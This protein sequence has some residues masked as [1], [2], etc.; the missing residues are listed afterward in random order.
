MS[1]FRCILTTAEGSYPVAQCAY[2]FAQ[3]TTERGRASA[4]VRSGLLTLQ[5]DVPHT[6]ELLAWA[7]DPHKKLSGL[8]TFHETNLPVARENLAFEDG[9][10]VSYDEVF[11]SGDEPQGAY[12][13]LLQISAG[14]LL[15]GTAEKDNTWAQTR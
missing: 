13:C 7:I 1:S 12:R 10:C 2:E 4:K 6:D 14:K 5:L 11:T 9:F 8:L 15:L 3:A